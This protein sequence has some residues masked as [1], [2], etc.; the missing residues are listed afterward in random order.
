MFLVELVMQGVRRF[1]DLSRLRFQSGFNFVAAGN[2]A[3]KTTA[4]DAMLR[5]LFPSSNPHSFGSLISRQ[6]PEASRGALVVYSDDGSYY[7]VIQDFSKHGVNLS[8]YNAATKEFGLLCKD[9]ES[10]AQFM[11]GLTAGMSESEFERLFLFRR[12]SYRPGRSGTARPAQ[13]PSSPR[14]AAAPA[15]RSPEKEARLAELRTALQKAEEAADAEYRAQSARL[16]LQEIGKKREVLQELDERYADIES[17][18]GEMKGCDTLPENLAN[19][20]EEHERNQVQKMA[21]ADQINQD[22]AGLRSQRDG[23]PSPNITTDPLFIV[24]A[25]LGGGSVIAA[26]FFLTTEQ[27]AFFPIG[28]LASVGFVVAAWYK[29]SRKNA[30]RKVIQKEVDALEAQ[31]KEVEKSFEKGGD[32]IMA[33][34]KATGASTPAELKEIAENYRYYRSLL[35]DA[36]EQR[37]RMQGS[38]SIEAIREEYERQQLE[39]IELEKAARAVAKDNIDTYSLRQDIERIEQEMSLSK[40]SS[41][42]WDFSA[43]AEEAHA[44]FGA[45]PASAPAATGGFSGELE[46]AGRVGGIEPDTLVPAVVAAAQRNLFAVTGGAYVRV[47]I[48]HG[49]DPVV[50]DKDHAQL[51]IADLSHSTAEAVYFCLRAGLVEALAGKIRLPFILDD[52]F[53]G[54]DPERQKAACQVLRALGAKTQVILLT[55]NAALRAQGDAAV[56]LK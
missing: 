22:I 21:E 56:E 2:E 20:I 54:F 11:T 50:H 28:V 33:C 7:R 27:A 16:R 44:D 49:S 36:A 12:D 35:A 19:M 13:A 17:K 42:A 3:G 39:V 51:G 31:L 14:P 25:L 34:M 18:L 32:R 8:K 47:D 10:A 43:G 6:T 37:E 48:A 30:E 23:I 15:G 1:K 5:M 46:I 40:P 9:W 29:S 55:S 24:G 45:V 26:L 38:A 52:P 53:A 41:A 4:A